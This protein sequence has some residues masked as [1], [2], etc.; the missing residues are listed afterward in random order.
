MLTIFEALDYFRK[1]DAAPKANMGWDDEIL[2]Y[3]EYP[4]E[5]Q[6]HECTINRFKIDYSSEFG[7]PWT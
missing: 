7:G 3:D 1:G 4:L 6:C 2:E 5:I